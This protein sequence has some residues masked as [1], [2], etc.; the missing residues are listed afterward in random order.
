MTTRR[1]PKDVVRARMAAT[2]ESYHRAL[3]AVRAQLPERHPLPPDDGPCVGRCLS[4]FLATADARDGGSMTDCVH[5]PGQVCVECGRAPVD[6]AFACCPGCADALAKIGREQRLAARCAGRTCISRQ[7]AGT[8][9]SDSAST[10]CNSCWEQMCFC[11]WVPVEPPEIWC[12]RCAEANDEGDWWIEPDRQ[13]LLE[14]LDY[15]AGLIA[16]LHGG[17]RRAVHHALTRALGVRRR[18]DATLEQ[19]YD[20]NEYAR[21]WVERLRST[22]RRAAAGDPPTPNHPPGR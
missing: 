1:V 14:E 3:A 20:A 5:C 8:S 9:D 10:T 15:L 19:L 16:K 21:K 4:A 6:T 18:T 11:G 12:D 22:D 17:K 7:H 2:G 13:R